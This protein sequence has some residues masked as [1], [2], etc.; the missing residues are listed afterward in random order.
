MSNGSLIRERTDL[1]GKLH[2]LKYQ[3]I[4]M[5]VTVMTIINTL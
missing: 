2:T 1:E 5:Q 3:I 4:Q